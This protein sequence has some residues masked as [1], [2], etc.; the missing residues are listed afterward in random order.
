MDDISYKELL[1]KYNALKEEFE[2][3]Q[4][5]AEEA[6][7]VI[8]EKN[9]DLEEKL[10]AATSILEISKYINSNISNEN[11]VPMINDM[12]IGV[13]G[14]SFSTIYIKENEKLI[15]K[16]TNIIDENYNFYNEEY[17]SGF[18]KGEIYILNSEDELCPK[19][20]KCKSI[21]IHCILGVPIKIE[22]NSIG[23]ILVEHSLYGFFSSEHISFISSVANQI[24]IALENNFLYNKL[25][26]SSIRDPLMGIYNRKY[27][28]N[29]VEDN[30]NKQPNNQFGIVMADIDDFKKVND[31]YGHQFGDE[32][33][34]EVCNI[35][36][37]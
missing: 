19:D 18:N 1:G 8:N 36:S 34:I 25:M 29:L 10:G 3:Y 35:I 6:F 31:V 22:S 21:K 14:V 4:K 13:L 16:A 23:Y 20:N 5:S 27:F 24:G 33:L 7:Q 17:L 11:L 37:S 30:I 28:F 32:V 26:D 15:V 9:V 2:S 12:I